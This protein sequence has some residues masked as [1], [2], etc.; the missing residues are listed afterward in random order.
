MSGKTK[1]SENT[2]KAVVKRGRKRIEDGGK[3]SPRKIYCSCAAIVE[4]ALVHERVECT[5]GND[6][7][8]EE[9]MA[10]AGRL[11]A[12]KHGVEAESI[13]APFFP[14]VGVK[15]NTKKR[16]SVDVDMESL[17]F[18]AGVPAGSAVYKDWNVTVRK[19]DNSD[20]AVF[21]TYKSHVTED[22][23]TKPQAKVVPVASLLNYVEGTVQA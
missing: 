12:E 20:A 21:I 17:V 2:E 1:K 22:K 23:K 7:K 3:A 8:D 10:E 14:R 16:E 9:L 15:A 4:G 6:S 5:L 19:I 13:D 18:S 11:F